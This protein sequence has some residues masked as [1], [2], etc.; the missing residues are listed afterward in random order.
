MTKNQSDLTLRVLG[1]PDT[2]AWEEGVRHSAQ[3]TALQW[4]PLMQYIGGAMGGSTQI[5]G[6]ERGGKMVAGLIGFVFQQGWRRVLRTLP[7]TT[8]HG[9][10]LRDEGLTVSGVQDLLEE[11]AALLVPH[12]D[13]HFDDWAFACAPEMPP[14]IPFKLMGCKVSVHYSYRE[15]LTEPEAMLEKFESEARRQIRRAEKSG[16]RTDA[17][18]PTEDDLQAI[19]EIMADVV[20]RVGGVLNWPKGIFAEITRIVT[21]AEIGKLFI[22]RDAEGKPIACALTL[23]DRFRVYGLLG[24]AER[25]KEG[26]GAM[27]LINWDSFVWLHERGHREIDLCG[28]NLPGIVQFKR[29]WNSRLVSYLTIGRR[30]KVR[31]RA[32]LRAAAKEMLRFIRG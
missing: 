2:G 28:G 26:I 18:E 27:R 3:G 31:R 24:G 1:V 13:A 12:L 17:C 20:E 21:D 22:T 14:A 32:H 15:V 8:Y 19:D 23:W 29:E 10:W 16:C 11:A 25:S 30:A 4:L 7:L 6:I 5:I 9:L